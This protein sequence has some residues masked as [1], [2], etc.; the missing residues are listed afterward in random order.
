M[1]PPV[2]YQENVERHARLRDEELALSARISR[3]RLAV[4]LVATAVVLWTLSRGVTPLRVVV[5]AALFSMFGVLVVWHARV[6]DRAEWHDARRL[7][8]LRAIARLARDWQHLSGGDPPPGLD[9]TDHPYAVDLNLFGRASL[10]QWLGPAATTRGTATLATWLLQPASKSEILARQEAVRHLTG[11]DEWRLDLSAHGIR[12]SGAREHEIDQFLRWAEGGNPFGPYAGLLRA[13]VPLIL[14]ALWVFILA[15]ASGLVP[16][17]LWS[18][19]LVLGLVLSFALTT[20]IQTTLDRAGAGQNALSRYAAIFEHAV[21]VSP[22]SPRLKALLERL[23]ADGQQAPRSMRRLNR[24]L[25]LGEL[26]R[27]AATLHFPVQ[28]LTL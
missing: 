24:I 10:F 13:I 9:L 28:A 1:A 5:A 21:A 14:A 3:A 19:P 8:N 18:I 4:F 15:H 16:V 2:P 25:G 11:L 20:V 7:V 23:S 22:G 17:G 6:E 12:A 27:G 26:R